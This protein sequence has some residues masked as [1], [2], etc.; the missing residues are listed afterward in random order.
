MY[1]TIFILFFLV[2]ITACGITKDDD[3]IQKARITDLI[4]RVEDA[5]RENRIDAIFSHYH[6]NFL[7]DGFNRYDARY[8]WIEKRVLY[9]MIEIDILNIQIDEVDAK[10]NIMINFS[11]LEVDRVP[12][13]GDLISYF[14]HDRGVWR[15]FGNQERHGE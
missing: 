3:K 2:F 9:H 13:P 12:F 10:V 7:H 11:S 1:R 6:D 4:K 8:W 15:I 14:Y 5:F